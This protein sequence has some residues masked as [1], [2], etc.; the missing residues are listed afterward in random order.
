MV[1]TKKRQEWMSVIA[2]ADPQYLA[3][4]WEKSDQ[5][6]SYKIIRKPETGLVMVRGR[7][8]G[9]GAKF[10]AGEATVTRCS[11][12]SQAGFT[13]HSYIL[14]RS[15]HHARIA[16]EID[17]ELQDMEAQTIIMRD[18]ITPLKQAHQAA[19]KSEQEKVAATKVDF[20][21]MVRGED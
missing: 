3:S 10:N 14:G 13:G 20:F 21:T 9:H 17:A 18:V 7:M 11:V 4:L 16:A 2:K 19:L 1:E 5:D 8:G 15:H 12:E 6:Q